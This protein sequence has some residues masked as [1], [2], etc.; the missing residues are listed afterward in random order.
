MLLDDELHLA[1]N[2]F[3]D[4][5]DEQTGKIEPWA[6]AYL[7]QA[8]GAYVEIS[9]SGTGLR[10]IGTSSKPAAHNKYP[11]KNGRERAAIEVYRNIET[12]RYITVTGAELNPGHCSALTNI[13][14]L[15]DCIIEQHRD[16]ERG[17][18]GSNGHRADDDRSAM[19]H[20]RVWQLAQLG[21]SRDEIEQSLRRD[22]DGVAAKY[23]GP[24]DRLRA[25]IER[26]FQKWR[27]QNRKEGHGERV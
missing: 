20:A 24:T 17:S 8:N 14:P 7:D 23:L 3:D 16:A 9:P 19:F 22:P 25:E 13:D 11:I 26:S 21:C 15:I 10:I 27:E 18:P 1:A 4:C 12:G 6:R 5:R 2:D